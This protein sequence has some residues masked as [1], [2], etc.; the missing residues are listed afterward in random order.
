MVDFLRDFV[1]HRDRKGYRL[2]DFNYLNIPWRP[3]APDPSSRFIVPVGRRVDLTT[4]RPF[5]S[6]GDL[7]L[8]F[9]AIKT[10][11]ELVRFVNNYGPLTD[12]YSVRGGL[13]YASDWEYG[14]DPNREEPVLIDSWWKSTSL[15]SWW[16][17]KNGNTVPA[18]LPPDFIPADS[19]PEVL[20]VAELFRRCLSLKERR[21]IKEMG[22]FLTCGDAR[23]L[24]ERSPCTLDFVG[25]SRRGLRLRINP[26]SLLS[27]LWFQLGLKLSGETKVKTCRHCNDF[28]ETGVGTGLRADAQFCCNEHKVEFFNRNRS[29]KKAKLDHENWNAST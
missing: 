2:V 12:Y 19:V 9:A 28:F 3:R 26:P 20:P 15:Q 17:Y 14:E 16:S 4:Y 8:V 23:A 24:S 22:L 11:D 27:A 13:W 5:A 29:P 7:C 10:A 6:G 25:D 18:N 1:W 21:K